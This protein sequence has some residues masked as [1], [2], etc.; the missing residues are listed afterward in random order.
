MYENSAG[1]VGEGGIDES[2]SAWLTRAKIAL[3]RGKGPA[4]KDMD[5]ALWKR[6]NAGDARF[7][8]KQAT[9]ATE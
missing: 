6:L 7:A 1:I 4:P 2:R 3:K 9:R 5:A 8:R